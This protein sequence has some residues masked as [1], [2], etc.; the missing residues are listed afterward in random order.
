MYEVDYDLKAEKKYQIGG[1]LNMARVE[2]NDIDFRN[3]N[4]FEESHAQ[5]SLDS[6]FHCIDGEGQIFKDT[7]TFRT[8]LKNYD[9]DTR[10]SYLYKKIQILDNMPW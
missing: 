9:V 6:W 4:T 10:R 8:Y 5:N 7:A 3:D 1:G 2:E